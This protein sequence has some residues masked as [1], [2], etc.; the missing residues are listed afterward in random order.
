MG[1]LDPLQKTLDISLYSDTEEK[2][3]VESCVA[4]LSQRSGLI[5][6]TNWRSWSHEGQRIESG[7]EDCRLHGKQ[8]S[9]SWD[10]VK[11]V[12]VHAQACVTVLVGKGV[13]KF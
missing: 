10:R 5:E 1:S 13:Q 12:R 6:S 7:S 8:R 11:H 9:R 4:L 3:M 2:R